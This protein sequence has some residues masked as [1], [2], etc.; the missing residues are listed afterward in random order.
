MPARQLVVP[1][2]SLHVLQR[3]VVF[4]F[5]SDLPNAR[6]ITELSINV[7]PSINEKPENNPSVTLQF[8]PIACRRGLGSVFWPLQILFI[9]KME[10][11]SEASMVLLQ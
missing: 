7:V 9:L 1:V 10:G 3:W 6:V 5:R 4:F 11:K 8:K 2:A